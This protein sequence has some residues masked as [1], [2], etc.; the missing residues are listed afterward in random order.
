MTRTSVEP[1]EVSIHFF[2]SNLVQTFKQWLVLENKFDSL[3]LFCLRSNVYVFENSLLLISEDKIYTS[4]KLHCHGTLL[5]LL[6]LRASAS[7]GS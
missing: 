5:L 2:N 1:E 3:L 4:L 7:A 6:T